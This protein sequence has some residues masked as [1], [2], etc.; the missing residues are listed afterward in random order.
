MSKPYPPEL[1]QRLQQCELEMLADFAVICKE[2][3]I[4]YFGV[5]GTG[6]GALRHGGFIPWDDDID[7]GLLYNDYLKLIDVYKSKYSDKYIIVDA[8]EYKNYPLMTTRITLKD[9]K[10]ITDSLKNIDCPMGIFL[11]IFPFFNI[12]QDDKAQKKQS[13]SAWF[14]GKILILKH[15][16]FPYIDFNGIKGKI[17]HC[18]TAVASAFV[19]IFFTHNSLYKRIMKICSRYQSEDTGRYEYFFGTKLGGSIYT[20]EELF[21]TKYLNFGGV[22][23]AFPN[24]LEALL[25]K[26]Y[27]DYMQ[28]PPPEKRKDPHIITLKFP[29]EDEIN[30]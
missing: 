3:N 20:K 7:I 21:P 26:L 6:I 25:T 8:V 10:F 28:V 14:W 24:Q 23:L 27:G 22:D 19:N 11:D 29:G 2:N 13:R 18:I 9:T 5:Y 17:I 12:S 16:P 4:D 30:V 15:T 1:L